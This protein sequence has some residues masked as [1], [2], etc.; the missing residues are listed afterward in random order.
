[1]D[2]KG[3]NMSIPARTVRART[4]LLLLSLVITPVSL[5]QMMMPS[6]QIPANLNLSNNRWSV[7][8][9]FKVA[10]V[11]SVSPIV[12]GKLARWVIEVRD[13]QNAPVDGADLQFSASMPGH[14]H[15]LPTEPK[16]SKRLG[17]GKY[18]LS[19]VQFQMSGWW[20]IKLAVRKANMSDSA[21]FNLMLK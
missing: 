9:R 8:K 1:L 14:M 17:N 6:Q 13:P 19:G 4:I 5:A 16:L 7:Q 10:Y 20:I 2:L 15:G 21:E 18:E 11:S 12:P 3:K